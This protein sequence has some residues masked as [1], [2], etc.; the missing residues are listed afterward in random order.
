MLK[1]FT[2]NLRHSSFVEYKHDEIRNKR[3]K[4]FI[5]KFKE[6]IRD[7]SEEMCITI[8]DD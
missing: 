3:E 8:T 7:V 5:N 2:F 6:A 4:D 1:K